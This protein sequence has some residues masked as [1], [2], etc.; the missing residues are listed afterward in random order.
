MEFFAENL[1]VLVANPTLPRAMERGRA[2]F[3][4]RGKNSGRVS[5][6]SNGPLRA[7]EGR[8]EEEEEGRKEGRGDEGR[9]VSSV[10]SSGC[11]LE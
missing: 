6:R 8:E 5:F 4:S 1:L 11:N 7:G 9:P 10:D 3:P 2:R